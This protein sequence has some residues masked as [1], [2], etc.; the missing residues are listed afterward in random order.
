M[1]KFSVLE[2][3]TLTFFKN[4]YPEEI[5]SIILNPLGKKKGKAS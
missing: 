2:F 3:S 1:S 4:S 5:C